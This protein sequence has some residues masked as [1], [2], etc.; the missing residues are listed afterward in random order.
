MNVMTLESLCATT[1]DMNTSDD[2]DIPF[3]YEQ[4]PQDDNQ[5]DDNDD[6]DDNMDDPN[7]QI[8][9]QNSI[10]YSYHTME[11]EESMNDIDLQSHVAVETKPLTISLNPEDSIS[12]ETSNMILNIMKNIELPDSAVPD[13]AKAIPES[14]W[15]PKVKEQENGIK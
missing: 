12:K 11:D 2:E 4:L 9:S 15:I 13:W 1:M 5:D 3:G 14:S 10:D 8:N 6:D 7:Q